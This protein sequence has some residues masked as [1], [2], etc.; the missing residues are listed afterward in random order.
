MPPSRRREARDEEWQTPI[1]VND[2]LGFMVN[3]VLFPYFAGFHLLL[4]D[5][6]LPGHRPPWKAWL[7]DGPGLPMDVGWRRAFTPRP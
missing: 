5:G 6:R 3:R 1:V 7:A 2:C 4:R